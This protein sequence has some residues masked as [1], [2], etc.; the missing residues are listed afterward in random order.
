MNL[1][2]C[3]SDPMH[4]EARIWSK[5]CR[6]YFSGHFEGFLA[7]KVVL[8]HLQRLFL[9]Q[10][11]P[12]LVSCLRHM[13]T[14]N[15]SMFYRQW[16]P[17]PPKMTKWQP[18]S[19]L[20]ATQ[21]CMSYTY[22]AHFALH[23]GELRLNFLVLVAPVLT[24]EFF[25]N[26]PHLPDIQ[27]VHNRLQCYSLKQLPFPVLPRTTQLSTCPIC[28]GCFQQALAEAWCHK[29][30]LWQPHKLNPSRKRLR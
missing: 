6:R 26:A 12:L 14:W 5:D 23:E 1:C 29:N 11:G 13:S 22:Q 17:F 4:E 15:T 28:D 24:A 2:L 9:K 30:L 3:R 7:L 20:I 16:N 27:L 18:R 8:R 19:V 21:P 10:F 25:P